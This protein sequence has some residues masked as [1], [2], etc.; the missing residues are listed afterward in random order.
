MRLLRLAIVVLVVAGG[1]WPAA[2][3][4]TPVGSV[5]VAAQQPARP[6]PQDEYVP[7]DQL[8]P[9]EELPAAPMVVAAYSFI[10]VAFVAYLFSL[11]KRL[12]KVETDL[13]VLERGRR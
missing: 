8:P 3:A 1:V 5:A 12:R 11:L 10:W 6:A 9:Q 7:I 2:P 13:A 4:F